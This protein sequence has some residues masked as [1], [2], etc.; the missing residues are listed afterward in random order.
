MIQLLSFG[1]L[2]MAAPGLLGTLSI[3]GC[4]AG[5]RYRF[6]FISSEV[7][8]ILL[9]IPLAEGGGIDLNDAVLNQC[10]CA[11]EVIVGGIVDDAKNTSF[12]GHR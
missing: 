6:L 2:G 11:D 3:L 8:S 12:T 10:V 5:V 7:D 1:I 9:L 4:K